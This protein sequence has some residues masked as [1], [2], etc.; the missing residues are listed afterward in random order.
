M[1]LTVLAFAVSAAV[2]LL[3]A[4]ADASGAPIVTSSQRPHPAKAVR[5]DHPFRTANPAAVQAAKRRAAAQL[6]LLSPLDALEAP[7]G[8]SPRAVVSGTLN[9]PGLSA[10][11]NAARNDGTP[12]DP[13]GAVG[14]NHY[15]EFVNSTVR[16]FDKT[17]LS[18]V[19][20]ADLDTFVGAM[21]DS[22]FDPQIQ[23]DQQAGRWLYL[24]DDCTTADCSSNN[25][26]AFG[27]SKSADPSDLVN[28]W[29]HYFIQTDNGSNGFFDDYPKLGHNDGFLIFGT[30]VFDSS[31]NFV[32]SRIWTVPKPSTGTITTCPSQGAA[33]YFS[34]S[35]ASPVKDGNIAT[36]PLRTSDGDFAFTPVPANTADASANGYVVA[37]DFPSPTMAS[38]VMAWHVSGT[39]ALVADGNITV[40]NYA[41]PANV[42]QPGGGDDL[43]SSDTR[44]TQAVAINDPAVGAEAVWTQ[45]TV[46]GSGNR[47]VVRW[48]E[49]IPSTDTKRQE[50]SISVASNFV[51]NGAIS[52]TKAGS[53]A[54]V[55]YNVGSSSTAAQ[56]RASSRTGATA[57]G[58]M[59]DEITLASNSNIDQDFSCPSNDPTAPSCRW[60]DYAGATPDPSAQHLV[61]GTN[62]LN[63]TP[64]ADNPRWITQNF[65]LA[66]TVAAAS[67]PVASFTITP[68]P[69]FTGK[70]VNFDG[71]ASDD[72]DGG[73]I[74]KYEWDFGTGTFAQDT[75]TPSHV[76][77]SPGTFTIRLRVTDSDD[78]LTDIAIM[79]LVV[80]SSA[81]TASFTATP[82]TTTRAQAVQF[83]GSASSD[84]EAPGGIA[85]YHWDFDGDGNIDQTTAVPTVSHTYSS[86]G[87]FTAKLIVTDAD[88]GLDSAPAAH[89]ITVQN[90]APVAQLSFSPAAPTTGETVS[91]SAAASSDPDGSIVHY[92]W[93]LDGNGTFEVD[94]GSSPTTSRSFPSAGSFP[95]GV[96]VQDSDGAFATAAKTVTVTAPAGTTQP[97]PAFPPSAPITTPPQTGQSIFALVLKFA[98]TAKLNTLLKSGLTGSARCGEVC[99]VR[100]SLRISKKL[101]RQLKTK[102]LVGKATVRLTGSTATRVRLRLTRAAKRA[103]A[104]AKSLLLTITGT[105]TDASNRTASAKKTVRI[106]R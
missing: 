78:N 51:F 93:D 75:A 84:A 43:D 53:E 67:P 99:T 59:T 14:P 27:F 13:T 44:L 37:A 77:N 36:N 32:S 5:G 92:R 3:P 48:Y 25:F 10:T 45:H 102:T 106:R 81:P 66:P 83:D 4:T 95:V 88:D 41:F 60:G 89:S 80:N 61:W 69:A 34:G 94:T 74:T 22:V 65:A 96:Q 73:T 28:G 12:P 33:H 72:P 54:I 26:L 55:Q 30:N 20:T 19:S 9:Q 18:T 24:T 39:G 76:F 58:T 52:P 104:H 47:S 23:W 49:L 17:N 82:S 90:T 103:L 38:Q 7:P 6:A 86:L 91:F 97:P 62:Q 68:S 21:N 11:D 85:S 98:R 15:V 40:A 63:G 2:A 35:A 8:A 70:T 100:L 1:R 31:N 64:N 105:A 101:A 50:G 79:Q 29:C 16:V 57:L 46:N 71:S 56:I 87:T 42:P